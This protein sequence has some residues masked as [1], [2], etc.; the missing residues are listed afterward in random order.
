MTLN[1]SEKL[2]KE[3]LTNKQKETRMAFGDIT[4]QA[5]AGFAASAAAGDGLNTQQS[6]REIRSCAELQAVC[7]QTLR[8][9]QGFEQVNEVLVQPR[10]NANGFANW[11]LAAVRP[12]VDNRFLRAARDTIDFLQQTYQLNAAEAQALGVRR[13]R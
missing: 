3:T 8:Q 4:I 2:G 5:P 6:P 12:R 11:T 1:E 13:R 7:L 9:C 10:A